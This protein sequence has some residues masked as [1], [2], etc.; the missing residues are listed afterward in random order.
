MPTARRTA[1]SAPARPWAA[2]PARY[3][4]GV[5]VL[6]VC[7]ANIC[8]SPM[9]AALFAAHA[10]HRRI[11]PEVSSAGTDAGR[12]S[13]PDTIPPEVSEV[14]AAHGIDLGG[15]GGRE[16]TARVLLQSDLVVGMGR[17]HIRESVLLDP[18][19]FTRAFTLTEL[20]ERG[21][22]VGPRPAGQDLGS[23]ILAA[24]G[25]RSRQ[26]LGRRSTTDDIADP[27]GG[28]LAGYRTTASTLDELTGRL[29]ALM[30]PA[31]D[32]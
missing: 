3:H 24:H 6:F 30:W 7:T 23:W 4:L 25:D 17:R 11:D 2:D 32:R 18:T 10:R 8:R 26:A 15:H 16:L 28:P 27:Y 9:A 14:M 31:P 21:A 22:Q 20:V 13:I 19:C 5:R 12:P 1:M 29:A